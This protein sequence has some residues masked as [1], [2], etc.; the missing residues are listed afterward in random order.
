MA[1]KKNALLDSDISRS[2]GSREPDSRDRAPV[3]EAAFS[4]SVLGTSPSK[5]WV[6][7]RLDSGDMPAYAPGE[8]F[9]RRP[10]ATTDMT[11]VGHLTLQVSS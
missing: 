7:S 10:D 4:A 11:V 6:R 1:R 3:F 2:E 9:R 8:Q 5:L